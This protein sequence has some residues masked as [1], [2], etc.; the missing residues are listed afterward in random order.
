[1][2]RREKENMRACAHACNS[3]WDG[4]YDDASFLLARKITF[5]RSRLLLLGTHKNQE[6]ETDAILSFS[7]SARYAF[8]TNHSTPFS[9][10]LSLFLSSRILQRAQIR[11]L[12]SRLLRLILILRFQLPPRRRPIVNV[13]TTSRLILHATVEWLIQMIPM[14]VSDLR[15]VLQRESDWLCF[16]EIRLFSL[17]KLV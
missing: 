16:S 8:S 7:L 1:M 10:S 6:R 12:I 15:R 17:W 14:L 5:F 3:I 9:F 4:I 2:S 13:R 11:N